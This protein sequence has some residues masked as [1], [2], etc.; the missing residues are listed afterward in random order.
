ME[1]ILIKQNNT[2]V[3]IYDENDRYIIKFYCI[4]IVVPL[5]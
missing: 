5:Q 3:I 2:K 4:Y 1:S